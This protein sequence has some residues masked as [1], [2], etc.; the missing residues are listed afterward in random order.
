MLRVF[1]QFSIIGAWATGLHYLILFSLVEGYGVNAVLA[2]SIGFALSSLFNYAANYRFTFKS[3]KK[4]TET[5]GKFMLVASVGFFLNGV[6][7]TALLDIANIHYFLAQLFATATVLVWN[8]CGNYFWS[9]R[10][11]RHELQ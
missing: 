9:F 3:Q 8:F 7:V 10:H 5:Y 4:H 1:L 11:K 6:V 2:T